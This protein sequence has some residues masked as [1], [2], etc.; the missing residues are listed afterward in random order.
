MV[1]VIDMLRRSCNMSER[2][3]VR[4]VDIH[5]ACGD[6]IFVY[7]GIVRGVLEAVTD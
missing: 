5:V 1:C 4:E 2:A 3:E 7:R 6:D